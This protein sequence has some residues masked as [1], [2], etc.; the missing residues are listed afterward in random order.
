MTHTVASSP[1]PLAPDPGAASS[2]VKRWSHLVAPRGTVLDIACGPGRHM[3]WFAA[4]GHAVTGVDSSAE[5]IDTAASFGEAVLADIENGPW[6]LMKGAQVRQFDAVIVT[7]YLW[8]PLFALMA[9]SVAPGGLLIYETFAQGN[10]TVGRPSRPDFLLR[11]AELLQAFGA[12]QVVAFE[13]GSLDNPPRVVQ[14]IAAIQGDGRAQT[15][16][17]R[18]PC[19]LQGVHSG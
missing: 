4:Q 12:M 8:R 2:W 14:R 5:A 9:Q 18:R 16:Q 7:N 6:P 3:K 19:P 13:E 10:E 17:T 11:P 15:A 1:S